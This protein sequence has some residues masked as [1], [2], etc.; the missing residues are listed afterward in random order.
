MKPPSEAPHAGHATKPTGSSAIGTPQPGQYH[1][2]PMRYFRGVARVVSVLVMKRSVNPRSRRSDK[3]IS[4]RSHLSQPSAVLT[5]PSPHLG[6]YT[7]SLPLE[8]LNGAFVAFGGG[9]RRERAEIPPTA[10]LRVLLARIQAVLAGRQLPDHAVASSIDRMCRSPPVRS[11][12]IRPGGLV[13]G[14]APQDVCL[15]ILQVFLEQRPMRAG[16][17][18]QFAVQP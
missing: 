15:V 14:G 3:P 4:P 10:G 17:H 9:P 13:T 7:G 1:E 2:P 18:V 6:Q 5:R 16:Q 12:R 11:G 8:E